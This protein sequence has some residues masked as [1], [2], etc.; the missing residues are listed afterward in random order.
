MRN[1]ALSD[2]FPPEAPCRVVYRGL[3]SVR[4]GARDAT[5]LKEGAWGA[6]F[7]PQP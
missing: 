2:F 1:E 5:K 6:G 3:T 7:L 4:G